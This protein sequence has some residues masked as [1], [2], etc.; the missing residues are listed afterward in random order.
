MGEY[1]ASIDP[2]KHIL[3]WFVYV[4]KLST[5]YPQ[6]VDNLCVDMWANFLLYDSILKIPEI[7]YKCRQIDIE[8]FKTY[9]KSSIIYPEFVRIFL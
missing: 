8:S 4:P 6:P 1:Y 2:G 7:L 5:G 9:I 3:S